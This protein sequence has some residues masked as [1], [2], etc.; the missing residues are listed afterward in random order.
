MK[1]LMMKWKQ[2]F[3]FSLLLL[4]WRDMKVKVK[5]KDKNDRIDEENSEGEIH[6]QW[7]TRKKTKTNELESEELILSKKTK[8]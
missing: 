4:I 1:E 8:K 3:Q 2:K 6:I 7:G 5:K